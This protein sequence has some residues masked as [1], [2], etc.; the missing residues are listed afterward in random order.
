MNIEGYFCQL[1]A[2]QY[3]AMNSSIAYSYV[4]RDAGEVRVLG[5]LR[6]WNDRDRTAEGL[7]GGDWLALLWA[8]ASGGRWTIPLNFVFAL[9]LHS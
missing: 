9:L 6:T 8:H 7:C 1:P 3:Q 4:R 5:A 2:E